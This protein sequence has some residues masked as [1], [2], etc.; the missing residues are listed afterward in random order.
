MP[1]SVC[2][3]YVRITGRHP[4]VSPPKQVRPM[5]TRS[6][7]SG[8]PSYYKTADLLIKI[9]LTPTNTNNQC[10]MRKNYLFYYYYQVTSLFIIS[11]LFIFLYFQ[12][13]PVHCLQK[14]ER[15]IIP[16]CCIKIIRDYYPSKEYCC[17]KY[18]RP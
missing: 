7:I 10:K 2:T 17:F 1:T 15:K 3:Y 5:H 18:A 12:E 11:R 6:T 9:V 13:I 14:F 4:E 8:R 16:S